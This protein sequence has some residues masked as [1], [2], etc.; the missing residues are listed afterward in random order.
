MHRPLKL[1]CN[2]WDTESCGAAALDCGILNKDL[3]VV[4]NLCSGKFSFSWYLISF[5]RSFCWF[6]V[7][8]HSVSASRLCRCC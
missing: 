1:H 5:C 8:A 2:V 6:S 3:K 7:F 4:F